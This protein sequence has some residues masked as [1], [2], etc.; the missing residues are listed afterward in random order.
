MIASLAFTV[1]TRV[2]I[3]GVTLSAARTN[4]VAL[5]IEA[6]RDPVRASG[7]FESN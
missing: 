2:N 4:F 5:Y 1:A 7:D 3:P 6:A